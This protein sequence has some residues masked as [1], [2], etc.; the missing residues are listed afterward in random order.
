MCK[1][2]SNEKW[3]KRKIGVIVHTFVIHFFRK[4]D[5]GN[6]QIVRGNEKHRHRKHIRLI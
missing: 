2:E 5:F 6:Y 4:R 3:D 1:E